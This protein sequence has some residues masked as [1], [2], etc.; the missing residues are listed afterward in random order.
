M[1]P[2][3]SLKISSPIQGVATPQVNN[4][5][6]NV[7]EITSPVKQE[8]LKRRA[9]NNTFTPQDS[10]D[11]F[12]FLWEPYYSN[13]LINIPYRELY[14][15][16]EKSGR[17][18]IAEINYRYRGIDVLLFSAKD[19]DEFANNKLMTFLPVSTGRYIVLEAFE[20]T[21]NVA[22]AENVT[23]AGKYVEVFTQVFPKF[24]L[25][26][27]SVIFGSVNIKVKQFFDTVINLISTGNKG[28]FYMFDV[29]N[30]IKVTETDIF[31]VLQ[32][33]S[34]PYYRLIPQNI[35]YSRDSNDNNFV[36]ITVSGIVA[37]IK[38]ERVI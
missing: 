36:N 11:A 32:L 22:V 5:A 34:T 14:A 2:A 18:N 23:Q 8:S 30:N 6:F 17:A 21:K 19:F 24:N 26:I 27:K 20:L 3:N 10:S 33:N 28:A 9:E 4:F 7:E 16:Y 37:D 1:N 31:P 35:S 38:S 15:I 29:L 12:V 13:G 25:R